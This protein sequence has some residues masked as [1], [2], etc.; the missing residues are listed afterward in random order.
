MIVKRFKVLAMILVAAVLTAGVPTDVLAAG[1]ETASAVFTASECDADGNFTLS[2]SVYN[3]K[4]NTFQFVLR[5]DQ[6]TVM[7]VDKSGNPTEAFSVFAQ[8]K[9]GTDWMSSIGTSIDTEKGLIDFTG[10]VNPGNSVV[11][12]G[13]TEYPGYVNVGSSGVGIY[14]FHFQKIGAANAVI[15]IADRNDS[16]AYSSFL[17]EGAALLDAGEKLPVNIQFDLP[18]SVGTGDSYTPSP[19]VIETQMTKEERLRNTIALQI[20]NYGAASSGALMRIDPDNP[21]VKPYIDEND[22]TMVPARFIAETLGADVDWNPETRQIT[23]VTAERTIVM[24]V[25]SKTY[26]INGIAYT[27]DTEPVI[28]KAWNR[29]AVPIRFVSQ[30]L[31]RAVEWDPVNRL[32]LITEQAQPWQLSREAEKQATD[33]ILFV[34][35]DLVRDFT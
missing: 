9:R 2:L 25:G 30:A 35:S 26:T 10:F 32:V 15:E 11:L 13:L 17:P 21:K 24:T 16:K 3:A 8:K 22:R 28:I 29:T 18:S 5:Y 20:G 31:G 4:F 19:P 27:M 1:S 7:P 14:D 12:D 23:I 33:S 34:I 6:A